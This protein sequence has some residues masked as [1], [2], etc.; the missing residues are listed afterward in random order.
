MAQL[1]HC[2]LG[3]VSCS[4]VHSVVAGHFGTKP[5]STKGCW[6]WKSLSKSSKEKLLK[7]TWTQNFLSKSFKD[8]SSS[9][10]TSFPPPTWAMWTTSWSEMIWIPIWSQ[11]DQ[12]HV[13]CCTVE[14]SKK[15]RPLGLSSAADSHLQR[16]ITK[17]FSGCTSIHH[18]CP[19]VLLVSCFLLI[20]VALPKATTSWFYQCVVERSSITPVIK[21]SWSI[22]HKNYVQAYTRIVSQIYPSKQPVL[23][24]TSL[25]SQIL[26]QELRAQPH[27]LLSMGQLHGEGNAGCDH[28]QRDGTIARRTSS[29][30][31]MVAMPCRLLSYQMPRPKPPAA[32]LWHRLA[33]QPL[34]QHEEASNQGKPTYA[35]VKYEVVLIPS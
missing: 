33:L 6:C 4:Q 31:P 12:S 9:E 22:D 7:S 1:H 24:Q 34:E 30:V 5:V 10:M 17:K 35:N 29:S 19:L 8:V 15:H 26:L 18:R 13:S 3:S 11:Q 2:P 27:V 16:Q 14:T 20:S 32:R 23:S 28:V 21:A 25:S